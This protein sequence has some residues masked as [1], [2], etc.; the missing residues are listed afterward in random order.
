MDCP[1][2]KNEVQYDPNSEYPPVSCEHCNR[3][4][5][6]FELYDFFEKNSHLFVIMSVFGG[7]AV[8]LP[9]FSSSEILGIPTNPIFLK[10][11][12]PVALILTR[13]FIQIS[14]FTSLILMGIVMLSILN[15]LT[16]ARQNELILAKSRIYTIRNFDP[17]RF[18]FG[19]PFVGL[20]VSFIFYMVLILG[21]LFVIF[22]IGIAIFVAIVFYAIFK[23]NPLIRKSMLDNGESRN[24]K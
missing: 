16:F 6:S 1:F 4:F 7:I 23:Q 2:C 24:K 20:G 21:D 9:A 14:I 15:E 8:I 5:H 10:M 18:M 13:L 11:S 3:K 12:P 17:Q 22:M 19:I